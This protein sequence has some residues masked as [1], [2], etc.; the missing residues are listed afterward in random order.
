MGVG[1][2]GVSAIYS[3]SH[4]Q[5]LYGGLELKGKVITVRPKCNEKFYNIKG[6][7]CKDILHG[8]VRM[9]Q[10][11]DYD[12]IIHLLNTYCIDHA[13]PQQIE[14]TVDV[15]AMMN[16]NDVNIENA[17]N[18]LHSMFQDVDKEVIRIILME[19]CWGDM[20]HATD[21]LLKMSKANTSKHAVDAKIEEYDTDVVRNEAN[22]TEIKEIADKVKE[23]V[24]KQGEIQKQ[25]KFDCYEVIKGRCVS[26]AVESYQVEM[27]TT[28]S[29]RKVEAVEV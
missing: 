13:F 23:S 25:A 24:I 12:R 15:E 17:V 9:P 5:G 21:V 26:R 16:L 1:D 22:K 27:R 28:D 18:T 11:A 2:G 4:T 7:K 19:Q 10:N 6:V 29:N 20:D 8:D 3:Y 14:E